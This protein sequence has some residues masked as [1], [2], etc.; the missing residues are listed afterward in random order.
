MRIP[1]AQLSVSILMAGFLLNCGGSQG[2]NLSVID[3]SFLGGISSYDQNNDNVV[4]CEEWKAA[5]SRLFA[6]ADKANSGFLTAETFGNLA[7][8]DRTF[9]VTD[10]KYFDTDKDGKVAKAEFVE[11]PNPAFNFADKDKD[12]RLTELELLSARSLSNPPRAERVTGSSGPVDQ[13][14]RTPASSGY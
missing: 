2:P 14:D 10:L 13:R 8:I 1:I 5:A 6:R 4:T 11:R 9:L 3:K 7:A 12:C